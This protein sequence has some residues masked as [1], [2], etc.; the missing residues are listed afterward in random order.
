MLTVILEYVYNIF[1]RSRSVGIGNACQ[2]G[3][4]TPPPK[5]GNNV[6]DEH[7]CKSCTVAA[8]RQK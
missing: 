8:N 2:Q 1:K 4:S 7:K 3:D 6:N 5:R